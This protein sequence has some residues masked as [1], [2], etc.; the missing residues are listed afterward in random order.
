[1]CDCVLFVCVCCLFWFVHMCV[2]HKYFY[3][4]VCGSV[5]FKL[6]GCIGFVLFVCFVC[7]VLGV[8]CVVM[9]CCCYSYCVL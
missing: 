9:H 8:V 3:I 1:M 7:M 5:L 6:Y 4:R 2:V